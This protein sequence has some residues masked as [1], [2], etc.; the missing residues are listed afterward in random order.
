MANL[1]YLVW[2]RENLVTP[3][4][5]GRKEARAYEDQEQAT[6]A[7]IGRA[8]LAL[9]AAVFLVFGGIMTLGGKVF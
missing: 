2:K 3:M 6:I 8:V 9:I 5:T 7:G 4:I 1:L